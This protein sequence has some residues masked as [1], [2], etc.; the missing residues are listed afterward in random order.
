VGSM[1]MCKTVTVPPCCTTPSSTNR[2]R[3]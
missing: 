1:S 2:G 3:S